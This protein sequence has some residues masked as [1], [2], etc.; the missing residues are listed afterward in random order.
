MS[1]A[2][3]A[4]ALDYHTLMEADDAAFV[5]RVQLLLGQAQSGGQHVGPRDALAAKALEARFCLIVDE[6][7]PDLVEAW[8]QIAQAVTDTDLRTR[9]QSLTWQELCSGL[10][11]TIR[12]F[13]DHKYGI[14]ASGQQAAHIWEE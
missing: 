8:Y 2:T 6:R 1:A 11:S 12:R 9:C 14:V 4:P 10:D 5:P 7:R 3:L 13:L